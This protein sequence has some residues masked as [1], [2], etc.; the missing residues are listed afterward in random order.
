MGIEHKIT[1]ADDVPADDVV[2]PLLA[3][4]PQFT[5]YDTEYGLHN[6]GTNATA[7]SVSIESDGF[8]VCDHLVD[9]ELA[10][11]VLDTLVSGIKELGIK[12]SD[13]SEV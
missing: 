2:H 11:N 10:H 13:V 1:L 4:L 5:I 3:A 6:F 8:L 7:V 9:R 12:I